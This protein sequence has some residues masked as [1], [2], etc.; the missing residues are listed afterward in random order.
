MSNTT[1]NPYGNFASRA[2]YPILTST[3]APTSVPTTSTSFATSPRTD[4]KLSGTTSLQV[5]ADQAAE[6]AEANRIA[7]EEKLEAEKKK[8]KLGEFDI[9]STKKGESCFLWPFT[10][11]GLEEAAT[12]A[13]SSSNDVSSVRLSHGDDNELSIESST[14]HKNMRRDQDLS[15]RDFSAAHSR[16][17]KELILL[18]GWPWKH[19]NALRQFFFALRT[20]S[21]YLQK[22]TARK[23]EETEL[24]RIRG[25]HGSERM[26]TEA[27]SVILIK[28]IGLFALLPPVHLGA[29]ELHDETNAYFAQA[30]P[31]SSSND[32]SNFLLEN[33]AAFMTSTIPDAPYER[34]LWTA[35]VYVLLFIGDD[36]GEVEGNLAVKRYFYRCVNEDMRRDMAPEESLPWERVISTIFGGIRDSSAGEQY[37][38]FARTFRE[39]WTANTVQAPPYTDL[40][41]YLR[42]RRLNCAGYWVLATTQYALDLRLTDE[43]LAD[44]KL[45]LCESLCVDACAMENAENHVLLDVA[46]YDKELASGSPSA[47]LVA[48]LLKEDNGLAS[49]AA[50][51]DHVIKIIADTEAKLH[52]CLDEA[53]KNSDRRSDDF[54]RYLYAIPYI[55]SGNVWFSQHCKRYNIPG[56]PVPRKVI[57][58]EDGEDFIE[59]VPIHIEASNHRIIQ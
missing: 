57:H 2:F 46:S 10:R 11:K 12:V 45:A 49:A 47:N 58:L 6:R 50:V 13:L 44:P 15:W 39:F 22:E 41:G 35:K 29:N 4:S 20:H 30:W 26:Q 40:E 27:R 54:V 7:E 23:S 52:S 8:P 43:E 51:K 3:C 21:T 59:P 33:G 24:R 17:I 48:L 16:Y 42:F 18:A 56:N 32:L 53:L 36:L 14:T 28:A 31:W 55:V 37:Q 1:A 5:E 25:H 9:D 19:V 38:R 34:A